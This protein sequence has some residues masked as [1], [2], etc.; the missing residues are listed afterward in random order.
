MMPEAHNVDN[1]DGGNLGFTCSKG[2][3]TNSDGGCY[4]RDDEMFT[5]N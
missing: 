2:L 5:S 4:H 3:K 1:T